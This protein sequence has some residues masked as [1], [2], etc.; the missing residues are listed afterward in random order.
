V[1]RVWL[2]G[3]RGDSVRVCTGSSV[4]AYALRGGRCNNGR[5][6]F[7]CFDRGA[8]TYVVDLASIH[9]TRDYSGVSWTH[10]TRHCSRVYADAAP[11]DS[12]LG[13][14]VWWKQI[15]GH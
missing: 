12:R 15:H 1:H 4:R 2:Y 10:V 8:S 5:L 13:G 14:G 7:A 9:L 6:R 3:L 11:T